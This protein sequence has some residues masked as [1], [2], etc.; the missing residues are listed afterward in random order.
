MTID[1]N[2]MHDYSIAQLREVKRM[3]KDE[4]NRRHWEVA[5]KRHS[6]RTTAELVTQSMKVIGAK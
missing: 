1:T 4:L 2:L 3:I 6:T 5:T